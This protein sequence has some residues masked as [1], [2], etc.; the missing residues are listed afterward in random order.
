MKRQIQNV[1]SCAQAPEAADV[2]RDQT[3]SKERTQSLMLRSL[4]MNMN[5]NLGAPNIQVRS[6]LGPKVLP[7]IALPCLSTFQMAPFV[8]RFLL[9][10][11]RGL[12][13]K[14]VSAR[15]RGHVGGN[16]VLGQGGGEGGREAH[17]LSPLAGP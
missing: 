3:Q 4:G 1:Q 16:A 10:H 7:N 11:F 14:S 15:P 2:A 13:S 6:T 8:T 17:G 9:S 12:L 5:H